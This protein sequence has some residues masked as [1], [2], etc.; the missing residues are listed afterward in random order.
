MKVNNALYTYG[1]KPNKIKT[2]IKRMRHEEKMK[3][4]HVVVLPV[5]D[6]GLL[7]IYEYNSLLHPFYKSLEKEIHVVGIAMSKDGASNLVLD[8]IQDMYDTDCDFDV[9]KFFDM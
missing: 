3:K 6:D 9:K 5:F 2:A 7:E 8:M 4:L 1:I